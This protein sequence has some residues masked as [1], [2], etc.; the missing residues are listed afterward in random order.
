MSIENV[1]FTSL[2]MSSRASC[3]VWSCVCLSVAGRT[4]ETNERNERTR[5]WKT[6]GNSPMSRASIDRP[7]THRVTNRPGNFNSK[8]DAI[9]AHDISRDDYAYPITWEAK[10]SFTILHFYFIISHSKIKTKK[11]KEFLNFLFNMTLL[12][13]CNYFLKTTVKW[14]N[15]WYLHKRQHDANFYSYHWNE[16]EDRPAQLI[17]RCSSV[18]NN[19]HYRVDQVPYFEPLPIWQ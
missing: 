19:C 14:W 10:N 12:F 1:N 4:D 9:L 8:K 18:D 5:E 2:A 3:V 17:R 16:I 13:N 7:P 6:N 15:L 11:N